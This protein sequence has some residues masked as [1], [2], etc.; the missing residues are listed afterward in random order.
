MFNHQKLLGFDS[1]TAF[2]YNHLILAQKLASEAQA[3][4]GITKG[5][6]PVK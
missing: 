5:G 1:L 3:K 2:Q 4:I 6:Y